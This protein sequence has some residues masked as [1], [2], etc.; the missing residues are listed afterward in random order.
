MGPTQNPTLPLRPY[1]SYTNTHTH[2]E[3]E[4]APLFR[5][6]LLFLHIHLAQNFRYFFLLH[7]WLR[8]TPIKFGTMAWTCNTIATAVTNMFEPWLKKE[9]NC[10]GNVTHR[11]GK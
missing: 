2:S 8:Q 1:Q 3:C 5:Y 9:K 4:H 11:D 7:A 10:H 6:V